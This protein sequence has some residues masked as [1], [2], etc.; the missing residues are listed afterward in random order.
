MA[1]LARQ[2][3]PHFVLIS[4]MAQGHMMPMVD[5]ARLIAERG[6]MV[7][8]VTTPY[9]A[10]RFDTTISRAKESGLPIDLVQIP[11]PCQEVG[12][13]IGCENLDS[14]PSRDPLRK[15]YKAL[16]LL[17]EPVENY[18][19]KQKLHPSCI[20]SDK[21]HW[22]TSKTAQKFNVP[23]IVFHGMCC[24]SLLSS[25]NV[26]AYNAHNSVTS[27]LE[28]FVVPGLPHRIE[29]TK[30][31][32]PGTFHGCA[33]ELSKVL[34]KK[35]GCIGPVSLCNKNNMDRFSRG[36][37]AS[38]DERQCLEWLESMKPRS[39]I[40]ACLGSHCRLVPSQ[41]IELAL[42]LEVSRQ[43]FIWVVKTSEKHLE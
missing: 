38:I 14:L 42:G 40:Y 36:N 41:L 26:K 37:K 24:F 33:E 34:E 31:Q 1:S 2:K 4:L 18:L 30:A 28:P 32:L 7:S 25:H 23:R 15:F 21:A 29:I 5:M 22:W 39:V 3:Q 12:L 27:D 8:L 16:S 6:V 10:S 20:I 11:F 43:P 19:R 35:V 13:P 9:N 17:Q